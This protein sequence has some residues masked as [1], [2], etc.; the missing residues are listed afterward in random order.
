MVAYV[1]AQRK[2][3][4]LNEFFLKVFHWVLKKIMFARTGALNGL[5][6][7]CCWLHQS[8]WGYKDLHVNSSLKGP[9]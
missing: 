3:A 7:F 6:D 1:R 9:V 2:T 8:S 4:L 5:I